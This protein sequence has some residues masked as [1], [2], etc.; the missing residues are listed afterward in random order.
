MGTDGFLVLSL[1][2][3]PNLFFTTQLYIKRHICTKN[4]GKEYPS[5]RTLFIT[6]PGE[7][8]DKNALEDILSQYV[9]IELIDLMVKRQ[10]RG[11]I[12]KAIKIIH[13]DKY[14]VPCS[15]VY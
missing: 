1:P 8:M 10:K 14:F 9:T 15:Y 12:D 6:F 13:S 3:V 2:I 5:G 7:S 4:D 11:F